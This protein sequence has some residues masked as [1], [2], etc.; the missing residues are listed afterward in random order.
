VVVSTNVLTR[1]QG[2]LAPA[3]FDELM[4]LAAAP[5][6]NR[7]ALGSD[8]AFARN[9]HR[10][11]S[12]QE[13]RDGLTGA[14]DWLEGDV[15]LVDGVAVLAH[16]ADETP[17]M[18]LRE[19]LEIGVASQRGLKLDVKEE[20]AVAPAVE[21]VL[22]AGIHHERILMNVYVLGTHP[23]SVR[24]IEQV[25]EALPGALINL[26]PGHTAYTRSVIDS[27]LEVAR[28]IGG[29]VM[30]PLQDPLV[31]PRIVNRLQSQGGRV[32]VWNDPR[33]LNRGSI[34]RRTRQLR[35]WGVR[36]MVDLRGNA[37]SFERLMPLVV[38]ART[39]KAAGLELLGVTPGS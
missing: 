14:Y 35:E 5:S 31:S 21:A 22:D 19:W 39:L 18:T 11:D 9:K 4:D 23:D 28:R 7:W 17:D 26:S 2:L 27:L 30:F 10:T 1:P 33:T 37:W 34:P 13:L 12:Y 16:D 25:R 6:T 8:I 32:A 3:A 29:P 24:V 36:G 15:R 20:R 38:G